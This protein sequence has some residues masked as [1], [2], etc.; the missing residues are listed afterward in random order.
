[1]V[2][3]AWLRWAVVLC[4][5]AQVAGVGVFFH[6]MWSLIRPVGSQAREAQGERF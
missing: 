4:G 1:M 6:T 5:L 2:A 3:D